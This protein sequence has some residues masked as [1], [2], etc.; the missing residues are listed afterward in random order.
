MTRALSNIPYCP[1]VTDRERIKIHDLYHL[2]RTNITSNNVND[3]IE[4]ELKFDIGNS[5]AN[6]TIKYPLYIVTL[7]LRVSK[8]LDRH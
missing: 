3:I 1:L 5:L 8:I 7:S 2:V 4:N 6:N